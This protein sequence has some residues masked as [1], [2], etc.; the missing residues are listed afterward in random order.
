MPYHSRKM[1]LRAINVGCR[2]LTSPGTLL[3]LQH[4][5]MMEVRCCNWIEVPAEGWCSAFSRNCRCHTIRDTCCG[6]TCLLDVGCQA[7]ARLLTE[8]QQHHRMEECCCSS[9]EQQDEAW[10]ST[11][12]RH[13]LLKHVPYIWCT[14]EWQCAVIM[15]TQHSR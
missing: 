4:Y 15:Q 6:R 5:R 13:F 8:L 1:L 10:Y 11:S 12:S 14:Y 7:S 9:V 3:Q 2:A